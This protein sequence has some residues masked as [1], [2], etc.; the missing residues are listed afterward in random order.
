[1]PERYH[2]KIVTDRP[3][4]Y[5][6]V[7]LISIGLWGGYSTKGTQHESALW[8]SGPQ[9]NRC[10]LQCIF[11]HMRPLVHY[12]LR[13][14]ASA[15]RVASRAASVWADT[16]M[17]RSFELAQA[18]SAQYQAFRLMLGLPKKATDPADLHLI[19]VGNRSSTPAS[20]CRGRASDLRIEVSPIRRRHARRPAW[21]S[22]SI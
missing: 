5:E 7:P 1:V 3:K 14:S 19:G 9:L 2:V 4:R 16:S 15:M 12:A 22:L 8:S 17:R 21:R 13:Y 6:L 18:I 20:V 10:V 11:I